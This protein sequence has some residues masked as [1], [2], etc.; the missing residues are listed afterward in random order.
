[1]LNVATLPLLLKQ[2]HLPSMYTHW[3]SLSHQAQKDHW[4]YAQYLTGLADLEITARN[5]K[6]IER[7]IKESKLP[8]GKSLVT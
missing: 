8:T 1:M 6:R 2:L 5:Q 7:Y 3:E 4:S